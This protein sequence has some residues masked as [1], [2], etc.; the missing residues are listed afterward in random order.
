MPLYPQWYCEDGKM[1]GSE[2]CTFMLSKSDFLSISKLL[3]VLNEL[4]TKMEKDVSILAQ[5]NW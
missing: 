4:Q 5:V 3:A 1:V 2:D